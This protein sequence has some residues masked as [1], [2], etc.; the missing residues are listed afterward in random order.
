MA[1]AKLSWIG[2]YR[3]F[4]PVGAG[5]M[6]VVYRAVDSVLDRPVAIKVMSDSIAQQEDL[7]KRFLHEARAAASLQHPNI[8]CVHD[9]GDVDGH[10]FIAMEFVDGVDLER[11][12]ERGDPRSVQAKLDVVIDVLNGLAFA[13]KRGI[14]HRDIKPA[15]IRVDVDGRAKVMDFGVA[16]LVSS[17]M[18]STGAI[19]GTPSYMAPEQI[20]EGTTS[21]GTD[22]FA[23]GAVLY[24]LLSSIKPFDGNNLQ[25]LLFRIVSENPR[26]ISELV[27]G[28]PRELDRIVGK[29]MAKE[30]T[31]RYATAA[32]MAS[33]LIALRSRL[34]DASI[35]K[36]RPRR[37]MAYVA[38][39]MV[40]LAAAVVA[41][42]LSRSTQ[43]GNA[44]SVMAPTAASK[45]LGPTPVTSTS[46]LAPAPT[47][48][49]PAIVARQSVPVAIHRQTS[50]ALTIASDR[51]ASVQQ[52]PPTTP[53]LLTAQPIVASKQE[54]SGLAPVVPAPPSAPTAADI[55]PAV[56]AYARAIESRSVG[57]VR[58]VQPGL[59]SEQQRGFEQ[60]FQAA[61]NITVTLR[62]ADVTSSGTSASARFVGRY[63]YVNAEGHDERQPI[64]VSA[65][66]RYDGKVWRLVSVR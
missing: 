50:Q 11:M 16:H 56:E 44:T 17:S 63:D 30:P 40:V 2:K 55:A 25:N 26:P 23:I 48:A 27:P 52:P 21:P 51:A 35:E 34:G 6:G 3:D 15:N 8:V 58:S 4:E 13:H 43:G 10:L 46:Q 41:I 47:A 42:M 1:D 61:Q 29:A 65:T 24:Q 45:S 9:F 39:G 57:A 7:R 33:D 28:L 53:A 18:T 20:T 19:L 22:I 60:L 12:I 37:T 36:P 49:E 59:T 32:D 62:V 54:D 38:A 14:V 64:S 66:L 5:A 31:E